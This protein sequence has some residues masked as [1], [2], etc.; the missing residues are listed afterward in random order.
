MS[1]P[2]LGSG[3]RFSELKGSLSR[4]NGVRSPGALAAWIGDLKYGA[5]KMGRL[6]HHEKG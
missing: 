3:R 2:R 6:S 4:K 1:K 5:K